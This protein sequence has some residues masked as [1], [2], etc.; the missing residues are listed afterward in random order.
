VNVAELEGVVPILP[1]PLHADGEL[2]EAGMGHLVAHCVQAGL[3]GV[4]LLGS[5][6]EFPYL[7]FDE[8]RRAMAAAVAGAGGRIPVIGTASAA[9]TTQAVELARAAK[10]AGCDAVMA[11]IPT[12]WRVGAG[13]ARD[14]VAAVAREGGLPVFFYYFPE[15]T[16]LVLRPPQIAEIA[17]VDGVV[18]AKITVA[19][20]RFL[21]RVIEQT[22]PHG[23]KVF[24]GTSFLLADCLRAGGAGVFCPLPLLVPRAVKALEHAVRQGDGDRARDLQHRLRWATPLFSGMAAAP[25]LQ[26]RGFAWLAAAP[27]LGPGRRPAPTHGLLKE[28]LR[29]RGHPIAGAVRPPHRPADSRQQ[30]LVRRSLAALDAQLA[31]A[32]EPEAGPRGPGDV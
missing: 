6:G 26:A 25:G 27:Y 14:H 18:G 8:K 24:T 28:A 31:E 17:A 30:E 2:D 4:V 32:G 21:R 16:G 9:G 23:W 29:Q 22:R 13:E 15:V 20:A 3:D 11:T 19:N 1:T 7:S 5:N 12:Y 10:E